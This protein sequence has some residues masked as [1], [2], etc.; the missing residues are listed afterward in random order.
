M[1]MS[2][3]SAIRWDAARHRLSSFELAIFSCKPNEGGQPRRG[4]ELSGTLRRLPMLRCT[5]PSYFLAIFS[6]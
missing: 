1:G 2:S 6:Q 4:P 3:P 5:K